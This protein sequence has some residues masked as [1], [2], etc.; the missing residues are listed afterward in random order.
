M[1]VSVITGAVAK[2]TLCSL[3]S[4]YLAAKLV[5]EGVSL[6]EVGGV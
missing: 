4:Y 2:A 5:T 6:H 1:M 3:G